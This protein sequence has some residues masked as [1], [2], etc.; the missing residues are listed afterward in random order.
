M[1][2]HPSRTQRIAVLAVTILGIISSSAFLAAPAFAQ[3]ETVIYSFL[4]GPTDGSYPNSGLIADSAGNLYGTTGNGG[5]DGTVFEL[6][7]NSSG[8]WFEYPIH[9][10]TGPDGSGPSGSLVM[11]K[12]G[13]LYGNTYVGGNYNHGV[14]FELQ[15]VS[16]YQ[17]NE[18]VLHNFYFDGIS[19]FDGSGPV[20]GLV[21]GVKG[22]IYG[23]TE[24]GGT[25]GCFYDGIGRAPKGE[26]PS[27][28]GT[29]FELIPQADGN[30][31]EKILYNFQGADDGGLPMA[32]L[33]LHQGNL[34]G[35]TAQG[36]GSVEQ[37]NLCVGYYD[38]GCGLVFEF[39]HSGSGWNENVLYTFTGLA[40]GANPTAPV[41]FDHAGNIYGTTAG[42]GAYYENGT[43]FQLSPVSGGWTES[44]VYAF[45]NNE[46]NGYAAFGGV[47]LDAAGNLYGTTQLGSATQAVAPPKNGGY[48][49]VYKLSPSQ[50]SWTEHTLHSFTGD[51]DGANPGS[52]NLLLFKGGLY[53]TTTSGGASNNGT[54]FKIVP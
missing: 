35:T 27:G 15:R 16:T 22:N 52:E 23:T 44:T 21:I 49:I 47:T 4:G 41:T 11:D 34:Y 53:G 24:F 18:I 1:L 14:V 42:A 39:S 17:W 13:N 3:S 40:D 29:V 7:P 32:G 37:N 25:G 12:Q 26:T 33:T 10:F 51:P 36:G 54:I 20:G 5:T 45:S 50:G 38:N 28:C 8:G 6:I 43:V 46:S 31:F 19:Y 9:T 2:A 30:W 48:G